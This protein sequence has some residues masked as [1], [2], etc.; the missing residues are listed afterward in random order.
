[1]ADFGGGQDNIK[2]GVFTRD[3][4]YNETG[5]RI[6][7]TVPACLEILLFSSSES[8]RKW[9]KR[10]RY[11]IFDEVHCMR[12][13]GIKESGASESSGTIW[14]HCLLLIRLENVLQLALC[15]HAM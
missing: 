8:H 15:V 6:L 10:L 14:E 13:G 3:F 1:M 11:V 4:R 5:A 9:V 7:I 12:E 2:V